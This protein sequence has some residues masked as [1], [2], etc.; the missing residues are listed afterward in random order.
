[1]TDKLKPCPFCGGEAEL[2][3]IKG[4]NSDLIAYMVGCIEG[5]CEIR[6][7]IQKQLDKEGTIEL[8]NRRADNDR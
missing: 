1:M 5:S 6:P 3:E 8:W 7:S 2:F 4:A